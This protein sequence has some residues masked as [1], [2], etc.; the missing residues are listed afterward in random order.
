MQIR[1]VLDI[2]IQLFELETRSPKGQTPIEPDLGGFND[3]AKHKKEIL[4][5]TDPDKRTPIRGLNL[6]P[7]WTGPYSDPFFIILL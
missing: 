2:F 6:V 4:K 7:F 5:W 1:A 3:E